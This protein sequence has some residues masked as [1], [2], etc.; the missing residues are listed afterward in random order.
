[1]NKV[2]RPKL[3]FMGYVLIISSVI[4][5]IFLADFLIRKISDGNSILLLVCIYLLAIVSIFLVLLIR[6]F[7]R[8]IIEK[9][10]I[11]VEY[12]LVFKPKKYQ[13]KQIIKINNKKIIF[14]NRDNILLSIYKNSNEVTKLLK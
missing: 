11:I 6:F 7:K 10:Y 3:N 9:G 8:I 4:S 13:T 14:N 1:M 12:Y 2:Y 5:L